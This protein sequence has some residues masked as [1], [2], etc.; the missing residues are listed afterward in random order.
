M[1]TAQT[2]TMDMDIE[3]AALQAPRTLSQADDCGMRLA[4]IKADAEGILNLWRERRNALCNEESALYASIARQK[5]ALVTAYNAAHPHTDPLTAQR[6][7][8]DTLSSWMPEH[9]YAF[10]MLRKSRE[11]REAVTQEIFDLAEA[12]EYLHNYLTG[13]A[14]SIA[15]ASADAMPFT[16][17]P[18]AAAL[19]METFDA[20]VKTHI[21]DVI[22]YVEQHRDIRADDAAALTQAVISEIS[23][24]KVSAEDVLQSFDEVLDDR[25]AAFYE[26]LNERYAQNP[27]FYQSELAQ[28]VEAYA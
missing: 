23:R 13:A 7:S 5:Q 19:S 3:E 16:T 14:P 24:G 1:E 12:Q 15:P 10:E 8:E 9:D 17:Q 2:L 22:S 25:Y 26:H 18:A 4:D 28:C 6:V 21:G 20:L 11:R 27:K